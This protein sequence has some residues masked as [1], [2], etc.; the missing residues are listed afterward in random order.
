MTH[1]LRQD[2]GCQDCEHDRLES[3]L[4][5]DVRRGLVP[6]E[7]ADAMLEAHRDGLITYDSLTGRAALTRMGWHHKSKAGHA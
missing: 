3:R 5:T 2:C 1:I 7:A 6:R 4:D